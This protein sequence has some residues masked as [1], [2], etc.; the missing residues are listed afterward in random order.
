[1]GAL[2]SMTTT[3]RRSRRPHFE[4]VRYAGDA[5]D[6]GYVSRDA[7]RRSR[8]AAR[9]VFVETTSPRYRTSV[10]VHV[11]ST[12]AALSSI[13]GLWCDRVAGDCERG[14]H[15]QPGTSIR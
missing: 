11:G 10:G 6:V 3:S 12:A 13:T 5:L 4:L 8:A 1:M 14:K 9:V 7:T 15:N 2:S